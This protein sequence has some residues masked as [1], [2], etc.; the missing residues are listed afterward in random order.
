[1]YAVLETAKHFRSI[2]KGT[3]MINFDAITANKVITDGIGDLVSFGEVYIGNPDLV[4]RFA[5][6]APLNSNDRTTY[7]SGGAKGFT[8]YSLL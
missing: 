2:Y 5:A 8:D 1:M 3:L 6:N 4:E 7:Y